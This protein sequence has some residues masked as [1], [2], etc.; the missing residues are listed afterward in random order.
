M[1][2]HLVYDTRIRNY[3]ESPCRDLVGV[4][5]SQSL[6]DD[7][8][9]TKRSTSGCTSYM[10]STTIVHFVSWYL[11]LTSKQCFHGAFLI[12]FFFLISNLFDR[13]IEQLIASWPAKGNLH[14]L[15]LLLTISQSEIIIITEIKRSTYHELQRMPLSLLISIWLPRR[16]AIIVEWHDKLHSSM[17]WPIKT[18]LERNTRKTWGG[19]E[20]RFLLATRFSSQPGVAN[21]I[22]AVFHTF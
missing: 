5:S 10:T 7:S 13:K 19:G 22:W 8:Y 9:I 4:I 3:L 12:F 20:W 16:E 18:H 17:Q 21:E 2:K 1:T 11:F 15:L 6:Y 14:N